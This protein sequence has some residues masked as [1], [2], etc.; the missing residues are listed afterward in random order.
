MAA[1]AAL[2]LLAP[3]PAAEA[4]EVGAVPAGRVLTAG[5]VF[6][7]RV[8]LWLETDDRGALDLA[9]GGIPWRVA[10]VGAPPGRRRHEILD[11]SASARLVALVRSVV[12]PAPPGPPCDVACPLSPAPPPRAV[13][14]E[15]WAG[16][17]SGPLRRVVVRTARQQCGGAL[18]PRQVEVV[19]GTVLVGEAR[20]RR[21]IVCRRPARP[22]MT[23]RV[24]A[25]SPAGGARVL[26]TMRRGRAPGRLA[27]EGRWVAWRTRAD[28]RGAVVV[29]DR[30]TSRVAYRIEARRFA[31]KSFDVDA[32]G[33]AALSGAERAAY[34][35]GPNEPRFVHR[36]A[37]A[38]PA[39]DR[40]RVLDD[41]AGAELVSLSRGRIVWIGV[42]PLCLSAI[43]PVARRIAGGF[44]PLRRF[45]LPC[46][47]TF[48]DLRRPPFDGSR[49]AVA[50]LAPSCPVRQEEFRAIH[51][52]PLL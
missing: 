11:L 50:S 5:P 2:A 37:I 32:S 38:S 1:I 40:L 21:A 4:T 36:L 34:P 39:G 49:L 48:A 3:V 8:A 26:A 6:A 15:V 45:A 42:E 23:G 33:R 10:V 25:V 22:R 30:R 19:G 7:G 52:A 24:L 44:G 51:T 46:T 13:V 35:C 29:L 9:R 41:R 20:N 43:G 14:D 28:L 27:A 12:L 18:V 17:P 31:A 47:Y 16:P